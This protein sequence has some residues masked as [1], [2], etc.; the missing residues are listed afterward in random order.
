MY[1]TPLPGPI[2]M[3]AKLNMQM[4]MAPKIQNTSD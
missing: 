1:I 3:N 2:C 4:F